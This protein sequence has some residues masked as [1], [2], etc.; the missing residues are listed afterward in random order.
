VNNTPI[1]YKNFLSDESEL[2]ITAVQGIITRAFIYRQ[3]TAEA[4]IQCIVHEH[5]QL[6][7]LVMCDFGVS[8]NL[9]IDYLLV[10]DKAR[11][12]SYFIGALGGHDTISLTTN[13]RHEAQGTLSSVHILAVVTDQASLNLKGI[14]TGTA[15]AHKSNADHQQRV[16]VLTSQAQCR[17]EPIIQTGSSPI[18]CTHGSALGGFDDTAVNALRM[19]GYSISEAYATLVQ[20]FY[21][22]QK[23]VWYPEGYDRCIAN[24]LKKLREVL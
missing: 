24:Y 1:V 3:S 2:V 15:L 21:T 13:Q 19:R 8:G 6:D 23:E 10:G 14:I 9:S 5:A 16:I 17:A 7:L 12:T 18:M 11:V 20:S 4:S 22:M